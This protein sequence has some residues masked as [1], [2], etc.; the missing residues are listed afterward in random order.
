MKKLIYF[1]TIIL[2]FFLIISCQ[3]KKSETITPEVSLEKKNP[4]ALVDTITKKQFDAWTKRWAKK[5]KD[6]MGKNSLEYFSMPVIDMSEFLGENPIGSRF[7]IGLDSTSSGLAPH[8]ILVGTDG[9]GNPRIDEP[10]HI[11]DVTK[12]CPPDCGEN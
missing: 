9:Q 4:P 6:Y 8:V 12:A 5:S 2:F 1:Q 11:Y 3:E 10:Y 7:Y